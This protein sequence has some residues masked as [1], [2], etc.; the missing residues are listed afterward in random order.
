MEK[1]YVE[2]RKS[3]LHGRGLF[4]LCDIP[5]DTKVCLY[6]GIVISK[7]EDLVNQPTDKILK[8]SDKYIIGYE[9]PRDNV[10]IGQFAN[11]YIYPKINCD[12]D[13][14]NSKDKEK[15][16]LLFDAYN[17]ISVLN[18]SLYAKYNDK[19]LY[20]SKLVKKDEELFFYYGMPYWIGHYFY[21]NI[22]C[23]WNLIF[24]SMM[25][26]VI[27]K[28]IDDDKAIHILVRV[29]KLSNDDV[30]WKTFNMDKS[31]SIK[32]KIIKLV[33]LLNL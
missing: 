15:C 7:E 30:I 31:L 26:N 21:K 10:G 8:L 19:W 6:D 9:N 12:P 20:T 1:I 4:A 17:T 29:M 13:S 32:D 3:S 2:I 18:C 5:K 23:F 33:D 25:P 14:I 24:Y 27:L 28:N 16:K 11:D 22:S